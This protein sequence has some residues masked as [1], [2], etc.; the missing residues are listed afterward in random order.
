VDEELVFLLKKTDTLNQRRRIAG[1]RVKEENGEF[2]QGKQRSL[3]R[4]CKLMCM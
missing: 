3:A 1:K 2:L 4:T